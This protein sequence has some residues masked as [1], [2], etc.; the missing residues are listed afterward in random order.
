[1]LG[2]EAAASGTSY[3]AP[4]G[5]LL[6]QFTFGTA[7]LT[8]T[9]DRSRPHGLATVRWDDE[10]VVPDAYPVVQDG[11]LVDYHTTRELVAPLPA[12]STTAGRPRRSHGCAVAEHGGRAPLNQC[13]N[14]TMQ[15][16]RTETRF[17]DLVAGL[18]RG[19]V[20]RVGTAPFPAL[21][22]VQTDR[23][24]LNGELVPLLAYEVRKGK[25]THGVI[26][27]EVLFRAPELWRSLQ[28][29]G[30]PASQRTAGCWQAKG[31]PEQVLGCSVTAVPARFRQLTVTDRLRQA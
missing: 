27:A 5:A 16:G 24:Q 3:L 21:D 30:G 20:L 14:L 26:G 6:G 10:G 13:P 25:R 11:V 1:V 12:A 9:A 2:Y 17:E 23:Q 18:E 22:L 29:I 8:V 28:A 15:P 7:L 31:Q 19:L 4:P